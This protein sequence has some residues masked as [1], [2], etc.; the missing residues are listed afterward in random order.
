MP[1]GGETF[2]RGIPNVWSITSY[3]PELNMIFAPTGNASPDYYGAKRRDID[4]EINAS[5]VAINA[6]TGERVWSYRTVYHDIWDYDVPSQPTLLTIN[7]NG[8]EIPAVAQPTK[9][10]EIFLLDRRD[11]TPIWPATE[12]PDGSAASS[13]GECPVP[14][15]PAPGDWTSP[16]QPFSGLPNFREPRT[17]K[18]MWGLTPLDQLYCRIEFKK[19]RYE[20]HFTPPMPGGGVMGRD[21]TW[22][23]T[24][25]YPG[26][27]GG[28]NWPS[29]SVDAENGL[30][31]A[32]PM[33]LGNRIYLMTAE[34]SAIERAGGR[35]AIDDHDFSGGIVPPPA[36]DL[37]GQGSWDVDATR[38]VSTS[39]F[40]S[41]WKIPFTDIASD[42]LCF[43]PPYGV[44]TVIDLNNN[45]LLWKRPI[46]NMNDLGPFGL[47]PGLSMFE[48]GTPVYGGTMT[49]R[50]G[51]IF[52][53]GTFDST[54]RAIDL[55][56]GKTLWSKRLRAT[57]NGTPITYSRGGRQYVV[58]SVPDDPDTG[59][60]TGEG[61]HMI[62]FALPR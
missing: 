51:L 35:Q 17:E 60:P 36:P 26:N 50:S 62:A 59:D 25:Q 29:V 40:T 5:V 9:R 4:D 57:S 16:V 24:F 32:Q 14:Q 47:K 58:V 28:F 61:A 56:S 20:G 46:G 31:I 13:L 27:Q 34:E 6:D 15:N 2:T 38:Y 1:E 33:M 21:E 48:V 10:G 18:D 23:G 44:L 7:K 37:T 55:S 49:T 12:C 45:Q 22:G 43:E 41:K 8:E 54:F 42:M 11:G 30:L 3:D 39:R 52:Q 19:M 53:V